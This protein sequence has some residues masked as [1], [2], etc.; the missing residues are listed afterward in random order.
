M[1]ARARGINKTAVRRTE[2]STK[3]VGV[4]HAS[5][6]SLITNTLFIYRCVNL[7][8]VNCFPLLF[9]ILSFFFFAHGRAPAETMQLV[10]SQT[11]V[12]CL[13]VYVYVFASVYGDKV[14][15]NRQEAAV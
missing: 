10:S 4:R 5:R 13:Y 2:T 14:L 1:Y 3:R 11:V 6:P 8:Q 9:R 7:R 12:V 15:L